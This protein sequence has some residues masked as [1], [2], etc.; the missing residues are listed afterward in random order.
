MALTLSPAMLYEGRL[1]MNRHVQTLLVMLWR[2]PCL[3]NSFMSKY[4][5][6]CAFNE[7]YL[8]VQHIVLQID[9]NIWPISSTYRSVSV[10]K[11]FYISE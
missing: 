7:R 5:V 4:S 1:G 11:G 9:R 8:I 6:T 2:I 10:N 3:T